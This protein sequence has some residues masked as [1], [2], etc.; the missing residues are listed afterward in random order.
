MGL[1][2]AVSRHSTV[3]VNKPQ[4]GVAALVAV[5][6][7]AVVAHEV[8]KA[9]Q[10]RSDVAVDQRR[11]GLKALVMGS[12]L[13]AS[14]SKTQVVLWTAVVLYAFAFLLA[15]GRSS[16]CGDLPQRN[17]PRCRTAIAARSAVDR[18]VNLDLE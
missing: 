17:G 18:A 10:G 14:T 2:L 11:K 7:L 9:V 8:I 13:R 15:W 12:D 4:A 3:V 5:G 6:L 16:S 1:V